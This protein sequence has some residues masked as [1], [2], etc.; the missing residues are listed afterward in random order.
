M[1]IDKNIN[2]SSIIWQSYFF[3]VIAI[4]PLALI[5]GNTFQNWFWFIIGE[6]IGILGIRTELFEEFKGNDLQ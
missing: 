5:V 4:S 6:S 3:I 2:V 1:R